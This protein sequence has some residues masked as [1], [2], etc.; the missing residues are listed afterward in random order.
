MEPLKME[1]LFP[2][3]SNYLKLRC[4]KTWQHIEEWI[5]E[6]RVYFGILQNHHYTQ[7]V[8]LI[9]RWWWWW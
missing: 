9:V 4:K 8:V 3:F 5:L 2:L 7:D 1:T 6:I